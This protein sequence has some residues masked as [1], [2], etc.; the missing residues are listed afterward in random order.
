MAKAVHDK[1]KKGSRS[2]KAGQSKWRERVKS[3]G[4]TCSLLWCVPQCTCRLTL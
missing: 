1:N 3:L 4:K 2:K